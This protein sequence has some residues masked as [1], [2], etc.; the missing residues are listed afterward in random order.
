MPTS[1]LTVSTQD[2]GRGG[3]CN[4]YLWVE[5]SIDLYIYIYA[6]S[7]CLIDQRI[8]YVQVGRSPNKSQQPRGLLQSCKLPLTPHRYPTRSMWMTVGITSN[9]QG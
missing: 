8:S 6:V 3:S 7:G 4:T 1:M 9:S 2:Q 5:V